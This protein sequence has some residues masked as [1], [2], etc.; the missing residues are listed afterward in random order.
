MHTGRHAGGEAR[1][2][3]S[4]V[5]DPTPQMHLSEL[6]QLPVFVPAELNLSEPPSK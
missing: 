2:T 6:L 1:H 3:C 4:Q 5:N